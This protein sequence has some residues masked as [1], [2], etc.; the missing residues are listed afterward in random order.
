MLY[1][2]PY[3]PTRPLLGGSPL[4]PLLSTPYLQQYSV[5]VQTE[6]MANLLLEVGY[7]GSK[8]TNLPVKI[9]INQALLVPWIRDF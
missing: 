7:V 5:N 8:G 1:A 6:L 9:Q 4:D 3:S 2:P